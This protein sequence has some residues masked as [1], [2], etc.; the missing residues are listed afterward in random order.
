MNSGG[1]TGGEEKKEEA[2]SSSLIPS[3]LREMKV[4]EREMKELRE[5]YKRGE[6][7][8]IAREEKQRRQ[9]ALARVM[10]RRQQKSGDAEGR[11]DNAADMSMNHFER[12]VPRSELKKTGVN[13]VQVNVGLYCNQACTHCHVESSPLRKAEVMSD[14]VA[15]R[16]LDV[17]STTLR[18][19]SDNGAGFTLDITGGAPELCPAFRRLVE[20]A[21]SRGVR[22]IIDRCNLTVLVESGQEDLVAFLAQ[23]QVRIVAS[24]P[25][26]SAENVDSQR[27]YGVFERSIDGLKRLNDAGY[28]IQGSGLI[29]DLIYNPGGAFLPPSQEKLEK[30]YKEELRSNFGI[31]FNSLITLANLP[32]KRFLDLL[33]RRGELDSY[34][35]LLVDNFNSQTVSRL[36]CRDTVSIDWHGSVFD[37]DFNQALTMN[38]VA[39]DGS[40]DEGKARDIFGITSF[41]ELIGGDI[42]VDSHCFGCT[43]GAGSS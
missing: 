39:R 15:D 37:C 10:K 35:N 18:E 34:M 26:Y 11:S 14:D 12:M 38:L 4:E 25:C 27:G 40:T 21:R 36:M 22:N 41:H 43:A 7:R 8:A 29:L 20:G 31:E 9:V 28:G 3:T 5:R 16:V 17:I 32:I 13:T 19:R 2:L 1:V 30:A 23:N 42:R 6:A 33:V 24:M